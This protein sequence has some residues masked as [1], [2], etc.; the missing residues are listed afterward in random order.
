MKYGLLPG[1]KSSILAIFLVAIS[2]L[3]AGCGSMRIVDSQVSA[4]SAWSPT[5]PNTSTAPNA[6]NAETAWR[7]E[8]TPSQQSLQG[9]ELKAW[10][11]TEAAVSAELAKQR[12][13]EVSAQAALQASYSVQI[14]VRLQRLERGPHDEPEPLFL[15]GHY[16]R[17]RSGRV[18]PTMP[19]GA[20]PRPW[21]VR[22]V[23]LW[24]RDVRSQRIVYETRARHEGRWH[25]DA[26]V[27][28]AVWAAALQGFPNPPAGPRQVNIEI[29]R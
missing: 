23:S 15:H 4:F 16:V 2:L 7:W 12:W 20:L 18:I 11:Q 25:D 29:P 26:A 6:P 13:R 21:Y 1:T 24:I 28:P 22:E 10:Q 14:D 8:R 3:M 5:A 27:L 17:T 9:D 19:L